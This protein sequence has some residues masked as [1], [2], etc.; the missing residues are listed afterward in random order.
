MDDNSM[1]GQIFD[2]PTFKDFMPHIECLALGKE[3]LGVDLSHTSNELFAHEPAGPAEKGPSIVEKRLILIEE[4]E[5]ELEAHKKFL[6][7]DKKLAKG[8]LK[9]QFLGT[10]SVAQMKTL[11][12]AIL[13]TGLSKI[14]D[15]F[16]SD[17]PKEEVKK[18]VQAQIEHGKG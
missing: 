8:A 16:A 9:K 17:D 10:Y 4:I 11:Q 2:N 3:H 1:D 13:N 12:P 6:G 18:I 7:K 5:G 15:V 14:R